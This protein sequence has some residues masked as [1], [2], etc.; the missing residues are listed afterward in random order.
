MKTKKHPKTRH[1]KTLVPARI[2]ALYQARPFVGTG[3][4]SFNRERLLTKQ[5]IERIRSLWE[6]RKATQVELAVRYKTS[7]TTISKLVRG[8]LF[9]KAAVAAAAA[10]KKAA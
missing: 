2:L 3:N 5:Q 8:V 4:R 6:S 10:R 9:S 7:Q 1:R